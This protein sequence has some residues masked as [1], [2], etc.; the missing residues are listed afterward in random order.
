M[1]GA[2]A[3]MAGSALLLVGSVTA[4]AALSH[5]PRRIRMWP[6]MLLAFSALVIS[7][8]SVVLMGEEAPLG[9]IRWLLAIAMLGSAAGTV[10]AMAHVITTA[11]PLCRSA[12]QRGFVVNGPTGRLK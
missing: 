4:I 1:A 11:C 6:A 9:A 3:T 2:A 12:P 7:D 8:R 5:C 10:A